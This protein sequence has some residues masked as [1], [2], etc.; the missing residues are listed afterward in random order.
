MGENALLVLASTYLLSKEG[1]KLT[2]GNLD[3]SSFRTQ[4]ENKLKENIQSFNN[5]EVSSKPKLS[6][7]ERKKSRQERRDSVNTN[8]QEKKSLIG[9]YIP[10]L[11][12]FNIKGR[13]YDK[14]ENTPLKG[15]KIEVIIEEPI[16]LKLDENEYSTSTLED[17]T[18]EINVNFPILPFDQKVLLQPKFLY[19]KDGYLPATQEIL[20]LDREAKSDLNLYPLLNLETA[21]ESELAEL[22]NF[23]NKKI[24]EVNDIALSIPDKIIVA[25]RKAIMG[26]VNI[27]QNRLFPLALSL[28]LAFGITK[29]TQKNQKI[30]PTRNLLLS[31]IAKRNRIVKQLN[32]IFASLAVNTAIAAAVLFISNQFKAGRLQISTLPVPTPLYPI[33]AT[34]QQVDNILKEFE[35]QNKELNKQILIALVFLIA[36]LIIILSLLKGIDEL[37][38]E[39]AQEENIDLEPISQELIDLTNEAN[40]EGVVSINQI[41]G[42]TLEVQAMDQ[43][44][45]GKLK[46]R[47]AVGKNS[48]GI[49]L[50]KGDPSFSSSDQILIN[51]LAFYI[52]SNNLKAF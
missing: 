26:V 2:D 17:G 21:A 24:K 3:I 45:V 31:N 12:E 23:A 8:S 25:R 35:E 39:C 1:K 44:A 27:I 10:E 42:F 19:T 50:V 34:L 13:I 15:V 29:L 52:Q 14:K 48:Q 33:T 28:L 38:Q 41:N 6:R 37:T 32:Q 36:S 11:K 20:T 43:N 22:I 7:E 40:E 46:R 47:Q 18:F 16:Y 49:I 4:I 9:Q 5:E 51:E 30:C